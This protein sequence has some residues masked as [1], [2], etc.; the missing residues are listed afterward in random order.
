MLRLRTCVLETIGQEADTDHMFLGRNSVFYLL[1][2]APSYY[3]TSVLSLPL[4]PAYYI[5]I[6]PRSFVEGVTMCIGLVTVLLVASAAYSEGQGA[7]GL[8]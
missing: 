7:E 2:C 1:L 5:Y 4:P 8:W 6:L 3:T